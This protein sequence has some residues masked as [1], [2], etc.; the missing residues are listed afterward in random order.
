VEFGV[1]SELIPGGNGVYDVVVDGA[2]IFSKDRV[3]RFP[4]D[5]EICREIRSRN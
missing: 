2:L 4:E 1:A 3:G 5:G